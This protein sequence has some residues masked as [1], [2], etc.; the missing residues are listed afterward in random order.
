MAEK[1]CSKDVDTRHWSGKDSSEGIIAISIIED[2]LV[3]MERT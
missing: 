3:H 1:L 2:D